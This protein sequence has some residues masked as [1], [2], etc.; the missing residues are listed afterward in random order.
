MKFFDP[1]MEAARRE[2]G[3]QIWMER[4]PILF[5]IMDALAAL[6]WFA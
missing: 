3:R 6:A 5:R 1:E 4:H 2:M